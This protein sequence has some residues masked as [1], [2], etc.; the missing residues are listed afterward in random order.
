[1]ISKIYPENSISQELSKELISDPRGFLSTRL[2]HLEFRVFEYLFGLI[3]AYKYNTYVS[4]D[5]VA[6]KLGCSRKSV[7][8]AIG[9]LRKLGLISTTFRFNQT[10]LYYLNTFFN[11]KVARKNLSVFLKY[12]VSL[13]LSMLVF[14]PGVTQVNIKEEFI[15]NSYPCSLSTTRES[16][17]YAYARARGTRHDEHEVGQKEIQEAREIF[18]YENRRRKGKKMV[19]EAKKSFQ[20]ESTYPEIRKL[21]DTLPLTTHGFVTLA[22]FPEGAIIKAQKHIKQII[23]AKKPFSYLI[24]MCKA[25]CTENSIPVNWRKYYLLKEALAV[26]DND[27][28]VDERKMKALQELVEKT[29]TSTKNKEPQKREVTDA[30]YH[31]AAIYKDPK[32][33]NLTQPRKQETDFEWAE[34]VERLIHQKLKA[35]PEAFGMFKIPYNPKLALLER[36]ERIKILKEQHPDCTCRDEWKQ[37]LDIPLSGPVKQ[38]PLFD[39]SSLFKMPL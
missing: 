18:Q 38:Q 10:C 24:S 22:A 11:T 5:T 30:D 14:K 3:Q 17:N 31:S 21:Q 1:M 23:T 16:Y 37:E 26:G 28:V 9:H 34:N 36:P 7:N 19:D 2:S 35:D 6:K 25:Y 13:S 27:P 39:M 32:Y 33:I 29:D 15:I 12:Y 4:Q 8:E 20:D